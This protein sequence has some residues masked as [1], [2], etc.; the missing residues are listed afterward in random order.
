M[1]ATVRGAAA[2]MATAVMGTVS[3]VALVDKVRSKCAY[4]MRKGELVLRP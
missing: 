3:T 4:A 2:A 1:L